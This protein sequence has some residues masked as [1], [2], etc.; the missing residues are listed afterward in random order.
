M[1][2]K[3]KDYLGS[4]NPNWK[5]GK[6]EKPCLICGKVVSVFPC[7]KSRKY[8]SYECLYIGQPDIFIEP[9]ICLFIDGCYWHKCPTCGF[10]NG[11]ERDMFVTGELQKQGYVVIR[12]WE[13]EVNLIS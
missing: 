5:G 11:R 12:L 2:E 1:T 7:F 13:H 6:V 8:C 9:N 3:G 4:G 10:G